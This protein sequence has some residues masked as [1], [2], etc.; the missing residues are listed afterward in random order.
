MPINH[1]E[2]EVVSAL[3]VKIRRQSDALEEARSNA[4]NQLQVGALMLMYL[5]CACVRVLVYVCSCACGR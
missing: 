5:K 3:L 1:P 2:Q 4:E